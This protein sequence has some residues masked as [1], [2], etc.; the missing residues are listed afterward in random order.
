M[1]YVV[2]LRVCTNNPD[3]RRCTVRKSYL[4][5]TRMKWTSLKDEGI[6]VVEQYIHSFQNPDPILLSVGCPDLVTAAVFEGGCIYCGPSWV[7]PP[8][9]EVC[10]ATGDCVT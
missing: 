9:R 5:I 1:N 4:L 7:L 10:P 2:S 6:V 8:A 3:H